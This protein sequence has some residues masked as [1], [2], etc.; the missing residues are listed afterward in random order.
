MF[1]IG[2]A[3]VLALAEF[4]PYALHDLLVVVG[5]LAVW[6]IFLHEFKEGVYLNRMESTLWEM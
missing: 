6:E 3:E 2:A 1:K 5:F 4:V